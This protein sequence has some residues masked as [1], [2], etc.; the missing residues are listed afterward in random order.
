VVSRT[1]DRNQHAL[2]QTSSGQP[3]YL[4]ELLFDGEDAPFVEAHISTYVGTPDSVRPATHI[5][6]EM[7]FVLDGKLRLT[8][9]DETIDMAKGDAIYYDSTTAHSGISLSK[10]PAKTLN[11]H[12][13]PRK[14]IRQQVV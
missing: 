14:H 11:L 9:D 7:V 13:S 5:G 4:I 1:D 10:K 3:S 6:Q 8:L 12:F 2:V